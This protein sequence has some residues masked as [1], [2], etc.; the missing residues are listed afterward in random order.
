MNKSQARRLFS[1]S[2]LIACL[3]LTLITSEPKV[4]ADACEWK[5]ASR[6]MEQGKYWEQTCCTCAEYS[7]VSACE[8]DGTHRYDVCTGTCN[9][10]Q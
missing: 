7:D 10:I 5:V 1:L 2:V 8:W 9:P 6:C 4:R 3:A